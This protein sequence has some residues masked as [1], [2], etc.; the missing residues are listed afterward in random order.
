[1]MRQSMFGQKKKKKRRE[2]KTI[3][4]YLS[5]KPAIIWSSDT[6]YLLNAFLLVFAIFYRLIKLIVNIILFVLL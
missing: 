1:M 4:L 6:Y 2:E 5:S 3:S